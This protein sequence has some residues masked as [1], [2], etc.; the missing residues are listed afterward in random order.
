MT[1]ETL[2]A[3]VIVMASELL[4]QYVINAAVWHGRWHVLTA[5]GWQI[6]NETRRAT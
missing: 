2:R 3:Q 4:G 1:P 5:A 6:L